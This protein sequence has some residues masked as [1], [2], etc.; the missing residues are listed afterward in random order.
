MVGIKQESVWASLYAEV[1][2]RVIAELEAGRLHHA[3]QRYHGAGV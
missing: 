1:T 3:A 2:A